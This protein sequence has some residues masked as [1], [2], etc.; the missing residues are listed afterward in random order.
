MLKGIKIDIRKCHANTPKNE[1]L[2]KKKSKTLLDNVLKYKL[3]VHR[4]LKQKNVS[5]THLAWI[6]CFE[7]I[8]EKSSYRPIDFLKNIKKENILR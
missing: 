4:C 6:Q 8:Y 7:T 1:F 3:F 2:M 5:N